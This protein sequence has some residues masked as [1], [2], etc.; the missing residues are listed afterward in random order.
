MST[1]PTNLTTMS[2]EI[3]SSRVD[4]RQR[5]Q[6]YMQWVDQTRSQLESF[7]LQPQRS[8]P[9]QV[10]DWI[11]LEFIEETLF[12]VRLRTLPSIDSDRPLLR[13]VILDRLGQWMFLR[14]MDRT[15]LY[16]YECTDSLQ[17]TDPDRSLG[18][19]IVTRTPALPEGDLQGYDTPRISSNVFEL[20]ADI[21]ARKN[22]YLNEVDHQVLLSQQLHQLNEMQSNP[23]TRSLLKQWNEFPYTSRLTAYFSTRFYNIDLPLSSTTLIPLSLPSLGIHS[24]E[25]LPSD[26]EEF[27]PIGIISSGK[28]EESDE[29]KEM[30]SESPEEVD[31]LSP[32]S[33]G[34]KRISAFQGPLFSSTK[35]PP[36]KR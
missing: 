22:G 21:R 6:L 31:I 3:E 32:T 28:E 24:F 17:S 34:S 11:E 30:G 33:I 14:Q 20:V 16:A 36:S 12:E 7:L 8:D 23:D 26:E 13:T 35:R 9:L 4:A 27:E 10:N 25:D 29:L 5:L 18:F 19:F 2:S 1:N 15:S